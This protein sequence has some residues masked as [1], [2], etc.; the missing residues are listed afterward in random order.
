MATS[1]VICIILFG[2]FFMGFASSQLE[3]GYNN[4]ELPKVVIEE[5]DVSGG[6]NITNNINNTYTNYTCDGGTCYLNNMSDVNVPA[7]GDDEI[8]SWDDG[9]SNWI[10]QTF[11]TLN[12]IWQIIGSTI[13]PK[14]EGVNLNMTGGNITADT[15][16]GDGSLLT[17]ISSGSGT[18]GI[19]ENV[20]GIATFDGDA[21]VTGNLTID[22]RM[23]FSESDIYVTVNSTTYGIW[24]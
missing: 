21:N 11:A 7:P 4:E 15:Y 3:F 17:G 16:F 13:S 20:S 2:I 22:S 8:L 10:A 6:G 23:D 19:W 1:Q 5:P 12:T 14:T 24:I 18:A 9:T